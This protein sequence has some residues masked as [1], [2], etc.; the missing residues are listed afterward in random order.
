MS[1]EIAA[2]IE[3]FPLSP[4]TRHIA[5]KYS[6]DVRFAEEQCA[7]VWDLA[8]EDQL[9]S[10][11]PVAAELLQH[12]SRLP[13]REASAALESSEPGFPTQITDESRDLGSA[14]WRL[15]RAGA[16][17]LALARISEAQTAAEAVTHVMHFLRTFPTLEPRQR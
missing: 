8:R 10:A 14:A 3:T 17:L 7:L 6:D 5:E 16:Y 12:M 11:L 13:E 9:L 2:V 4:D 15:Q 1:P